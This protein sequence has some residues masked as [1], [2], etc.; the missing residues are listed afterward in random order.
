MFSRIFLLL[1]L[2]LSPASVVGDYLVVQSYIGDSQ[3]TSSSLFDYTAWGLP[4]RSCHA[5]DDTSSGRFIWVSPTLFRI[6]WWN[7]STSCEGEPSTTDLPLHNCSQ[8]DSRGYYTSGFGSKVLPP[9]PKTNFIVATATFDSRTCDPDATHPAVAQYGFRLGCDHYGKEG[10][11]MYVTSWCN[12]TMGSHAW[13]YRHGCVCPQEDTVNYPIGVCIPDPFLQGK[14]YVKASC[15][16]QTKQPSNDL[17]TP[18]LTRG[19]PK[20]IHSPILPSSIQKVFSE[21]RVFS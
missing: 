12:S 6:L 9:A 18:V 17:N 16:G 10:E 11:E 4:G 5:A 15:P 13:C 20:N 14:W 7:E 21:L 1:G 19:N 3:C 8:T 2:L